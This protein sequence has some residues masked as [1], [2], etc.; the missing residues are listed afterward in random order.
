M[1]AL[2]ILKKGQSFNHLGNISSEFSCICKEATTFMSMCYGT[3]SDTMNEARV[4]LWHKRIGQ[5]AHFVPKLERLPPTDDNFIE[6][7]KR[8]HL[9]ACVWKACMAS[10]PPDLNPMN[11]GFHYDRAENNIL[12]TM[13]PH[14]ERWHQK[15]Y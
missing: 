12:P 8:A 13:M 11:Y 9:Q 2:S 4:K 14:Q 7:V 5:T 1:K 10:S 6:N 15:T 3:P